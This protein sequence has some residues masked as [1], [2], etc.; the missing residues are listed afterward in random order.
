MTRLALVCVFFVAFDAATSQTPATP[1]PAAILQAYVT[2]IGGEAAIRRHQTRVIKGALVTPAG[3]APLEIRMK[4]PDKFV[5]RMEPPSGVSE[6]GFD[7]KVT[8]SK[9]GGTVRER[10]GP[11]TGFVRRENMLH[12]PIEWRRLYPTM[13]VLRSQPLGNARAW[14]LTATTVDGQKELQYFDV[15]SGR[16]LGLDIEIEGTA[17]QVRYEDYRRVDDVWLPFV[18]RRARPDF[19]WSEEYTE[20]LHD[21]PL[22]ETI[23]AKPG[24]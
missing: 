3:R 17:L 6:N 15:E 8:W 10:S 12:R 14:V 24:G 16:L 21:T 13:A 23:F 4:A 22:A 20:I 5:V 9:N 7:G 19:A 1:T 2:S 11:D 18:I